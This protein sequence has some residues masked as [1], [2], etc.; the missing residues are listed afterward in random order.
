MLAQASL[1]HSALGAA[2]RRDEAY[3]GAAW[4]VSLVMSSAEQ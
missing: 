3:S 4:L 1:K 2:E